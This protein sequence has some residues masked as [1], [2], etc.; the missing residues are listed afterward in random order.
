VILTLNAAP[1]QYTGIRHDRNGVQQWF[2][3]IDNTSASGN[4]VIQ[5]P[6]GALYGNALTLTSSGV[7]YTTSG[8]LY[9]TATTI[10]NVS[11][12]TTYY[13]TLYLSPVTQSTAGST[14]TEA[15]VGI[16]YDSTNH[17]WNVNANGLFIIQAIATFS[18]NSAGYRQVSLSNSGGTTFSR[19][20]TPGTLVQPTGLHCST[21]VQLVSGD[22]IYF[23]IWQNSGG[24]LPISPY[25][26][27]GTSTV[28]NFLRL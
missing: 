24:N 28:I 12:N 22:R 7:S 9:Y 8:Y 10:Q 25:G 27:V 11:S 18:P 20:T 4:Y 13:P 16:S 26:N 6:A 5:A 21:T 3:G 19:T 1:S 2:N 17:W 23:N 14:D 15:N